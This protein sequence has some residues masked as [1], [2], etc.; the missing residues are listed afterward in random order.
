MRAITRT[1]TYLTIAT[2]SLLVATS[3]L[4]ADNLAFYVAPDGKDANP[5]TKDKPLAT[6]EAARDAIRATK[7]AGPL[8]HPVTVWIRAGIYERT[9]T[10]DL[11]KDDA[12]TPAA[13]ITYRAF[14]G[15][16]PRLVGG[17]TLDPAWFQPVSDTAVSDRLDPKVRGKILQVDL[18]AHGITDFGTL[19]GLAGGLKLFSAGQRLPLARW[20]NE[21][22][23]YGRRGIVTGFD[24]S[25][26]PN[27]DDPGRECKTLAFKF[28]GAPPRHWRDLDEVWLSGFYWQEYSF[29]DWHAKDI[30]LTKRQITYPHNLPDHL[31]EWRRILAVHALEEIDRPGEWFLD[32]TK[33]V[34]CIYPPESFPKEPIQASM[35][36]QTMISLSDTSHVT[37]RGLTLEVSRATAVS[38]SGGSDNLI[39]GCTI[40]NTYHGLSLSGGTRNG[41][42][43]CDVCDIAATGIDI[44]GGDRRTLTPAGHYA[45]NNHIHH[46]SQCVMNWQPGIRVKG[47][48][49]HIAHNRIH[50]APQYGISYE[51]N[52]HVFEY[53]DMHDLD[54]EQSD[55]G[56]IGCGTDW[57]LRGNVIRYNFIHHIPQR[58]YPG[59]CG[60]YLD[61]CA[62]AAEV[63]GNVFYK[64]T[65]PVMIGG[66]RD[67]LVTNNVFIECEIP[68]YMDNR[69]L[70]WRARWG[71]FKPGGPMYK[72][73][74]DVAFDK[75]PWSTRYPK[76]ASILD[77][78]PQAPL[79]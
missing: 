42:V 5:G 46:Y 21:G 53:N 14:P 9:K 55:V 19:G 4:A 18:A 79:G 59:V 57:T 12:G 13:P 30:D 24:G 15:E 26:E 10:F 66:G 78:V 27:V 44:T 49:H 50:H 76:L 67:H 20:P 73:L 23:A 16:H 77:D 37:I 69:G 28:E 41:V 60:V 35:L 61:N 17:R 54:L 40:R 47:V 31:T 65:K 8:A 38:V 45:V 25:G 48:G 71:H 7:N 58:P 75:P 22:W 34:L 63:H 56:V 33:G 3:A 2:A 70:R 1:M 51:G 68:V 43:G 29:H 32:R 52:D 64:M 6:L 62:A 74:Q 72:K 11:T 39:A 36:T